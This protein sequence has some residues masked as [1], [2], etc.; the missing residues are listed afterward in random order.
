MSVAVG[1]NYSF[2]WLSLHYSSASGLLRFLGTH[3]IQEKK[4][5]WWEER[6]AWDWKHDNAV[7]S[8]SGSGL[9]WLCVYADELFVNVAYVNVWDMIVIQLES[10]KHTVYVTVQEWQ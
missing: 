2:N 7:L 4:A 9:V 8:V 3:F 6:S 5:M 10:D 1:C